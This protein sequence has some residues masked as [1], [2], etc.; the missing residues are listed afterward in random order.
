MKLKQVFAGLLLTSVPAS[1]AYADGTAQLGTSQALRAGTTLYVDILDPSVETIQWTGNGIITI[2]NPSNASLGTLSS[3]QT[4]TLTGQSAGAYRI[5]VASLQSR[6]STWDVTVANPTTAGGRLYSKDWAFDAGSFASSAGTNASFFAIVDGG[7]VE[8]KPVIELKLDGLAGY[9]YNI[10]ANRR[11]VNG[12]NAGRSVPM[13]GNSV[14]PEFPIYL[15]LPSVATYTYSNADVF[16]FAYVGGTSVDVF[17]APMAPCQ[18]I[19]PGGSEG[20][21]QFSSLLAGTYHLQCDLNDNGFSDADS[22][23]LLLVGTTTVG[24]NTVSWDGKLNGS[25]V[26]SGAYD[27]RVTMQVGEFHYVGSDIETSYQGLRMFNVNSNETRSGLTMFWDD[28]AVQNNAINMPNGNKGLSTAGA[29]GISAGSYAS[30]ASADSNAH[31]WG[32]FVGA[33]KGDNAFIDTFVWLSRSAS[34]SLTI[35]AANPLTD[36]D[37]DGASDFAEACVLGTDGTDADT[38]NNGVPDGTQY[39]GTTSTAQNGGLESNGRLAD[40]LTDRA[41]RRA[42]GVRFPALRMANGL[43][44]WT[45]NVALP[46]LVAQAATP[47]DLTQVSNAQESLGIDYVD[48]NGVRQASVLL[49]GTTGTAYEHS[50]EICDRAHGS[51]VQ[52]VSDLHV[53]NVALPWAWFRK[54]GTAGVAPTSEYAASW[55]LYQ[56]A[57]GYQFHAAWLPEQYPAPTADQRIVTVQVWAASPQRLQELVATFMTAAQQRG[58]LTTVTPTIVDDANWVEPTTSSA[59]DFTPALYLSHGSVLGQQLNFGTARRSSAEALALRV[60]GVNADGQM[61]TV[62]LGQLG[63]TAT[64][65]QTLQLP[66]FTELSLE[67]VAASGVVDRMWLSDGAWSR[68]D[69]GMWGGTT[70]ATTATNCA[71]QAQADNAVTTLAGCATTQTSAVDRQAGVAR[72]LARPLALATGSYVIAH[73]A[74]NRTGVMCLESSTLQRSSCQPM[75]RGDGWVAWPASAFDAEVAAQTT[76][77]SFTVPAGAELAMEVAGLAVGQGDIPQ[78][79]MDATA[80][81]SSGGCSTQGQGKG[82]AAALLLV[83]VAWAMNRRRNS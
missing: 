25:P 17:G 37:G 71:W 51:T 82:N 10:N 3:G 42:H 63:A 5:T 59:R 41:I 19:A 78:D 18:Q 22:A 12:V 21:F 77:I 8:H 40:A 7:S 55:K 23:D 46:G 70:T 80:A 27:C 1:H 58:A 35:T 28:S 32:N 20:R 56:G 39:L 2:Y 45:A 11:G 79:V 48:G 66:L 54:A 34:T 74:S 49:I 76:L 67:V 13:S 29:D 60:T 47:D 38:D 33:G 43:S 52:A 57:A 14:T 75:P 73:V 24:L 69:D 64:T 26:T 6:G 72:H 15:R 81:S 31:S 9:V 30:A 83:A 16:G 65:T 53:S 62:D 36:T 50:K 68:F 4:K 61:Q 44:Q